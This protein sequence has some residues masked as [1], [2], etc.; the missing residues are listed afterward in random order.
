M[1]ESVL[2][3]CWSSSDPRGKI[4]D[5]HSLQFKA[6]PHTVHHSD[7]PR[8]SIIGNRPNTNIYESIESFPE[9]REFEGVK[10]IRYEESI[11]YANVDN[12]K[13]KVMKQSGV[14]PATVTEQLK[15]ITKKYERLEAQAS[16]Q[17]TDLAT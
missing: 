8:S 12:F 4:A 14:N 6:C 16:G 9:A 7:R 17:E 5:F 15:G 10:I 1:S 13:Y 3:S 2:L 11:Y